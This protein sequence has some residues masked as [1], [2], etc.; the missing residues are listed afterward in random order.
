VVQKKKGAQ[1]QQGR[2]LTSSSSSSSL[3]LLVSSSL[4]RRK[5][6]EREGVGDLESS[7]EIETEELTSDVGGREVESVFQDLDDNLEEEEGEEVR[8]RQAEEKSQLEAR[9]PGQEYR[10]WVVC[11]TSSSYELRRM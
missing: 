3:L 4:G 10:E 7:V 11:T 2:K 9:S 8:G 6:R 5:G 1:K